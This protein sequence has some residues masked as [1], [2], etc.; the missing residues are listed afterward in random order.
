MWI[1]SERHG[2]PLRA[3]RQGKKNSLFNPGS[4]KKYTIVEACEV[5]KLL[6]QA[7]VFTGIVLPFAGA[8]VASAQATIFGTNLIVNAGAESGAGGDSTVQQKNVPGWASTGGCDIYTYTTAYKN[9]NAIS[10]QDIVPRGAG[11]NYFAGGVKPANCTFSQS[12]NLS[13]GVSTIDAGTATFAAA[14]Y[15]GGY[16]GD[17]DNATMTVAFQDSTG[18]QL[19]SVS[20]GTVGPNDRASHDNGLYL[21]RQIGQVPV[22]TRTA[23]VTLNMLWVN[24]SNNEAYA[25][26]LSLILN[27]PATPQSLVGVNLI[28]NPG[29]DASPGLDQNS[30]TDASTDLPGWVRSAYLTADS[31]QDPGGDLYQYTGGPSDAGVNYFY[32]GVDVSQD[33]NG[34]A[35]PATAFQDIDVSSAGSLIDAGNVTYA[36]SAWLGGYSSQ[37][38]NAQLA[39][40]FQSWAGAVLGTATLGP[41]LA[42]DR[43]GNSALLKVSTSGNVPK[44]TRVI[45][46]LL[47]MT[48]EEGTNNDGLADSLL[49]VL[50]PFS[51]PGP[52]IS[53]TV[54][55]AGSYGAFDSVAP[56]TWMEI[57]GE[58]LAADSRAWA[59]GDFNGVN[60]PTALDGTKVTIGGQAAFVYYISAGQIDALVPGG[61]GAG[62]Q[63]VIV[64]T[65]N[66]TSVPLPVT[67]N[68]VEPGLLAP[69]S[70]IVN[71]NLYLAA[72]FPDGQTFVLP[73]GAISGVPSRQ[74]KPGETIIVYGIGFGAVTPNLTVGQIV[75]QSNSLALPFQLLFGSTPATLPYSG[76]AP[77]YLGLYQFN[78]VVPN[79]PN[80]DLVPITFTLGGANGMQ[81]LYT[82]VHN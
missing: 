46:V 44:G 32:G 59:S 50:G 26:N 34:N 14:A 63:P 9:A 7:A 25:D 47:T 48:R 12:I 2:S 75:E 4:Q 71:G 24:G 31:Y 11:N 53:Q 27:A 35:L 16:G 77:N 69:S 20:I 29:A 67:V 1:A 57:Y 74:A 45:H 79:I 43:M 68:P 21:R 38:D 55:S 10:S 61:V 54:I 41:I 36:L 62:P 58:N 81:T 60:A 52:T 13:S 19:S 23:A 64:T 28:A 82:A 51:N 3:N 40:H 33:S 37:D 18:K 72:V 78:V 66:G 65:A 15:L 6:F 76:L 8:Q 17:G 39:V 49:L 22:G 80:S 73:P 70:F 30:T 56:G 5:M 42:A